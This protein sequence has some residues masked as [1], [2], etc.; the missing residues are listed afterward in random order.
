MRPKIYL[1]CVRGGGAVG[2]GRVVPPETTGRKQISS[3]TKPKTLFSFYKYTIYY[4]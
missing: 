3:A 4:I 2:D 1:P